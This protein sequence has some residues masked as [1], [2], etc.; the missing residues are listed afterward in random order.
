[1]FDVAE[2]GACNAVRATAGAAARIEGAAAAT[3]TATPAAAHPSGGVVHA[4]ARAGAESAPPPTD[5]V[6]LLLI[7]STATPTL[8]IVAK[9]P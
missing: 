2:A 4:P 7:C 1:M 8:F 9:T 6:G 3:T 5:Q